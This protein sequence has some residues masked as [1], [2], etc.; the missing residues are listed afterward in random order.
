MRRLSATG[1][2]VGLFV[3]SPGTSVL[4]QGGVQG[5]VPQQEGPIVS[6]AVRAVA[7]LQAEAEA[8][9]RR[10]SMAR[11]WTGVALLGGGAAIAFAYGGQPSCVTE[12]APGYRY[13]ACSYDS[14][15]DPALMVGSGLAVVGL[16]LATMWSD[17][18]ANAIGVSVAPGR[19]TVGKTFGF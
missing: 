5:G 17:V 6:S 19:V 18:P 2:I 11:T 3:S 1:L 4:A 16:L 15:D 8:P 13:E 12:T 7:T 10:R 14:D 9:A